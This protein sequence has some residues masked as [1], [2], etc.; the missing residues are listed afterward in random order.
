MS[1]IVQ[2]QVNSKGE[3]TTIHLVQLFASTKTFVVSAKNRADVFNPENWQECLK[4]TIE[5]KRDYVALRWK[6]T[7][8]TITAS[9]LNFSLP[10]VLTVQPLPPATPSNNQFN[11]AGIQNLF[12]QMFNQSSPTK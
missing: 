3:T 1:V 7:G 10:H 11:Q 2:T 12:E 5:E 6:E 4:R 8:E 9:V